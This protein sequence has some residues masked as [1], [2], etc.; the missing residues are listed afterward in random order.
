MFCAAFCACCPPAPSVRP[1]LL[2]Q[3]RLEPLGSVALTVRLLS[4]EPLVELSAGEHLRA[5]ELRL[6]VEA[7]ASVR[8][9][10]KGC[11]VRTLLWR[12]AEL[13]GTRTLREFGMHGEQ[14][15]VAVCARSIEGD[16]EKFRPGCATCL[17]YMAVARMRFELSGVASLSIS[18]QGSGE[19]AT[20]M[21]TYTLG[22]VE[23]CDGPGGL[24][25]SL[26]LQE[27]LPADGL[28]DGQ[29]TGMFDGWL[30]L[31]ALDPIQRRVR[32]DGLGLDPVPW[33]HLEPQLDLEDLRALQRRGEDEARMRVQMLF[34]FNQ[35]QEERGLL[36]EQQ[37]Y[38][39]VTDTST[40][41]PTGQGGEMDLYRHVFTRARRASERFLCDRRPKCARS[42]HGRRNHC[43]WGFPC[44]GRGCHWICRR[45]GDVH[46]EAARVRSATRRAERA[47][48]R[49]A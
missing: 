36:E 17:G 9:A 30:E 4:G 7:K 22:E 18:E 31:D 8:L 20:R 3:E 16:F 28:L 35:I 44:A 40:W 19:E 1:S 41:D 42:R 33:G 2:P 25:R 39:M 46:A 26:H 23:D 49:V 14:E 24:R 10:A 6:E 34:Q 45:Q 38:E 43:F 11:C 47:L 5:D 37:C 29:V 15:V 32:I 48:K 13:E 27:Q 12:S 21:F